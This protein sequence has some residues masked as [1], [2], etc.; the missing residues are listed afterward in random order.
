MKIYTKTGDTG[1]TSLIGGTRVPKSSLRIDCYGTVDELNS[2]IGLVRDQ[3]VNGP[4]REMLKEIQDRLFTIGASLASDPEKSK[5]KIPDLHDGDVLL[6]ERE[7]D[8][9]NE[10]LPE[11]REFILPGG[12]ASVSYAHV[13]RCVCR[14]A[15]RLAIALHEDAFVADLVIV[16]LNRL[17]D[18]LFVLSRQMAHDLGA[19]EV[20]WKPRL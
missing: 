16:Y 2:Y 10:H 17:S 4:R 9:M 7:I 1:L 6:L 5:M 14:R 15:E 12:H 19:E 11:L 18:Y 13:A 20:T 3:D 8:Q